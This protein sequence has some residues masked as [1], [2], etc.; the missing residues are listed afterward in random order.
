MHKIRLIPVSAAVVLSAAL[1]TG[2]PAQATPLGA[3]ADLR[4]AS[5]AISPVTNVWWGRGFH[6]GFFF[7]RRPFFHKRAFFF[8]RRPFFA[9]RAFAFHRCR[10]C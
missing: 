4:L 6:R 3:T 10:W 1:L 9:R 2:N 7:H 8:H 5:K